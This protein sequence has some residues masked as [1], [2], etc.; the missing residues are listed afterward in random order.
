[1]KNTGRTG[2]EGKTK[3]AK[4]KH[5]TSYKEM[6]IWALQQLSMTVGGRASGWVGGRVGGCWV[7]GWVPRSRSCRHS[8]AR[9]PHRMQTG[10]PE[11][12]SGQ[13]CAT[14]YSNL[15][16]RPQLDTAIVS[17]KKTLQR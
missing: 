2:Q 16:F 3:H 14:I 8:R 11:G 1:M 9:T 4:A 6:A 12:T 17:G 13:I 7:G 15:A 5:E 10:V